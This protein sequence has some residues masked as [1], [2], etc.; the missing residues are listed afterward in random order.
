MQIITGAP[1]RGGCLKTGG[2]NPFLGKPNSMPGVAKG[3]RSNCFFIFRARIRK[4]LGSR[5]ACGVLPRCDG[6]P[7]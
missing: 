2:G 4:P 6:T 3:R 7:A 5:R 1:M